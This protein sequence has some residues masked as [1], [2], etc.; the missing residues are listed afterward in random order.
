MDLLTHRLAL[1][2][3]LNPEDKPYWFILYEWSRE[4]HKAPVPK[5][6]CNTITHCKHNMI[7][8]LSLQIFDR[9]FLLSPRSAVMFS[10]FRHMGMYYSF[11]NHFGL[12]MPSAVQRFGSNV[13]SQQHICWWCHINQGNKTVGL[14]VTS[15]YPICLHSTIVGKTSVS[16]TVQMLKNILIHEVVFFNQNIKYVKYKISAKMCKTNWLL[17]LH[18]L[19]MDCWLMQTSPNYC[20]I[21]VNSLLLFSPVLLQNHYWWF[22]V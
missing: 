10:L 22:Y 13:S 20:S 15:P 21:Y 1:S 5:A 6:M 8:G 18:R 19:E 2:K 16:L 17:Y 9:L 11:K 14:T 4:I 12:H 3:T 7:R